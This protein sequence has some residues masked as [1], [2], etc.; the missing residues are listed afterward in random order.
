MNALLFAAAKVII[1]YDLAI[2]YRVICVSLYVFLTFNS[3]PLIHEK[4][5]KDLVHVWIF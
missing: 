2:P 1:N 4:N 3:M 5:I